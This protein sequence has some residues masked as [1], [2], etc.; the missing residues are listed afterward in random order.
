MLRRVVEILR[1][2]FFKC[3]TPDTRYIVELDCGHFVVNLKERPVRTNM[4]CPH[5][6][7]EGKR[8]EEEKPEAT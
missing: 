2:G 5:C 7:E 4:N 6:G 1:F 8:E 3:D